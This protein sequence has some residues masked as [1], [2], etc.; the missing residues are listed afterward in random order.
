MIRSEFPPPAR[1]GRLVYCRQLE[2][3]FG[4]SRLEATFTPVCDQ[5]VGANREGIGVIS[6]QTTSQ[7]FVRQRTSHD[8]ISPAIFFRCSS[9]RAPSD[10]RL[11][12]DR[13][14]G[15]KMSS[16]KGI[17]D[18]YSSRRIIASNSGGLKFAV[19]SSCY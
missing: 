14:R 17:V 16:L 19:D 18:C 4:S 11:R 1:F 8:I 12:S 15:L 5:R 3:R 9:L 7:P 13:N 2:L 6:P 10:H